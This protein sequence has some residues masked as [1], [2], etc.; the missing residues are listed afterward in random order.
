MASASPIAMVRLSAKIDTS[1]QKVMSRSTDIEPRIAIPPT[2]IGSAAASSPPKTQT[3][4]R[5][6]SGIAMDSMQQQV[7]LGLRI[8]LGV[9]HGAAAGPHRHAV[10]VVRRPASASALA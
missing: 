5:K 8:D 9:D 10:A 1:V 3:S 2:T 6:L 4:T 7:P